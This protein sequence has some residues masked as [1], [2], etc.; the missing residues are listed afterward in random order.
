MTDEYQEQTAG[1]DGA[2]EAEDCHC[3]DQGLQNKDLGLIW[4]EGYIVQKC[5]QKFD[6]SPWIHK[7]VLNLFDVQ[8]LEYPQDTVKTKPWIKKK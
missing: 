3:S 1:G 4:S 2:H 5:M 6:D 7:S 8:V